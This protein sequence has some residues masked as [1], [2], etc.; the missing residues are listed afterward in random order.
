MPKRSATDLAQYDVFL[1]VGEIRMWKVCQGT[2]PEIQKCWDLPKLETRLASSS[3]ARRL[4]CNRRIP[5]ASAVKNSMGFPTVVG[6][7]THSFGGSQ[8]PSQNQ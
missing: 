2:S 3:S 1:G 6:H 4:N 8:N 7:L 5:Y